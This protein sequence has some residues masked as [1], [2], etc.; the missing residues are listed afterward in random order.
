MS[1][2]FQSKRKARDSITIII[3][4][5]VDIVEDNTGQ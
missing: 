4:N 5:T 1:Y 2:H 3:E